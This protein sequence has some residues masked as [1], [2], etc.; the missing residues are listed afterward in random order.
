MVSEWVGVVLAVLAEAVEDGVS[1][2]RDGAAETLRGGEQPPR[3]AQRRR[4]G[5]GSE[6]VGERGVLGQHGRGANGQGGLE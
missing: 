2:A 6:V 3:V 1:V 5:V 4:L